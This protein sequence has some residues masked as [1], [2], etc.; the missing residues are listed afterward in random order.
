MLKRGEKTAIF[1]C[2]SEANNMRAS[3]HQ[4]GELD[5]TGG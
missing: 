2:E 4:Q 3:S 1:Q 5:G